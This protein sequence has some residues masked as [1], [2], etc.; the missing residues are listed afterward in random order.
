MNSQIERS[1]EKYLGVVEVEKFQDYVTLKE[2]LIGDNKELGDKL[3]LSRRQM[4]ELEADR[5][6]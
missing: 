2:K 3:R 1:I 5:L 6:L 4:M